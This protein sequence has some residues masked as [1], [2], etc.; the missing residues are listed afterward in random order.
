MNR[1]NLQRQQR[2]LDLVIYIIV[3]LMILGLML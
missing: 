1:Q 2:L 3:G